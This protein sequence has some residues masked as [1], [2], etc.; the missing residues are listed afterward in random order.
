MKNS[1]VDNYEI[2]ILNHLNDNK[3]FLGL[4]ESISK[5]SLD[6]LPKK[7]EQIDKEYNKKQNELDSYI[8]K[9]YGDYFKSLKDR[10]DQL[11]RL[12]LNSQTQKERML[13]AEKYCQT[14]TIEDGMPA[15]IQQE[16]KEQRERTEKREKEQRNRTIVM[17]VIRQALPIALKAITIGLQSACSTMNSQNIKSIET[18]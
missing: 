13:Y 16:I 8:L 6:E 17:E 5:A 12:I 9:F 3:L 14:I 11:E 4:I 10:R 15:F 2:E 1:N 18:K 7:L